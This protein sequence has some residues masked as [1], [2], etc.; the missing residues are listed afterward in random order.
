[1]RWRYGSS[2]CAANIVFGLV[3]VGLGVWRIGP[4]YHREHQ[5]RVVSAC[6]AERGVE[7]CLPVRTAAITKLAMQQGMFAYK[8]NVY[9]DGASEPAFEI[10]PRWS[11]RDSSTVAVAD[12]QGE[13]WAWQESEHHRWEELYEPWPWWTLIYLTLIL[14]GGWFVLN[15]A[16]ELLI[17]GHSRYR[18]LAERLV[19]L[20]S[21]VSFAG[22]AILAGFSLSWIFGLG[23]IAVVALAIGVNG[24]DLWHHWRSAWRRARRVP[25]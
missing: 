12:L 22:T 18:E 19:A 16:S 25:R 24:A 7:Q 5:Q 2:W 8:M 9:L 4:A 11:E 15:F 13:V 20:Y 10:S 17:E 6:I 21:G 14:I 1:M 3:L 23:S